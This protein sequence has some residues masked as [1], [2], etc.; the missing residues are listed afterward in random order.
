MESA[1]SIIIR[2]ISKIPLN[3]KWLFNTKSI[4]AFLL[5]ATWMPHFLF[6][7]NA[8][9]LAYRDNLFLVINFVSI[10]PEKVEQQLANTFV[11]GFPELT[12]LFNIVSESGVRWLAG[13]TV[14]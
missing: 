9:S 6:S 8:F 7:W 12:Q 11:V 3:V 14:V 1:P 5:S 4:R 13:R 2:R 10:L